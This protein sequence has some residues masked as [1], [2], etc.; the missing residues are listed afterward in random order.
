MGAAHGAAQAKR[1]SVSFHGKSKDEM[2]A[3]TLDGSRDWNSGWI[4]HGTTSIEVRVG[5]QIVLVGHNVRSHNL[6]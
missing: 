1:L 2:A 6:L 4:N 5:K 3:G